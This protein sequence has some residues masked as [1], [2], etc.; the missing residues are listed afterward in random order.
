MVEMEIHKVGDGKYEARLK[1]EDHTT[2]NLISW[3]LVNTGLARFAY[4]E[5]PHPL[6]DE[7]VIFMDIG[8]KDPREVLMEA[9]ERALKLNSLFRDLYLKALSEKGIRVEA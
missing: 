2:G 8:D 9:L 4:Y 7:I 3:I 5:P 1:G 6:R